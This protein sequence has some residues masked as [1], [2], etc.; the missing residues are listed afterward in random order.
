MIESAFNLKQFDTSE[1]WCQLAL[2]EAFKNCGQVNRGK[3]ERYVQQ[4][5]LLCP[6]DPPDSINRRLLLCTIF[7]GDSVK[8]KSTFNSM[9]EDTQN[10]ARTLYLMY[11]LAISSKDKSLA[12]QCLQNIS[13]IPSP[14]DY[15]Y[16]CV[17]ES[18][19]AGDILSAVDAL[20]AVLTNEASSLSSQTH[21]PALLRCIIRLLK[22]WLDSQPEEEPQRKI[23]IQDLCDVFD[24]GMWNR[25]HYLL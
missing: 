13:K 16:A 24:D 11:R 5:S 6:A 7:K 2:H 1:R 14:R 3:L 12:V 19:R 17:I 9:T 20:R 23:R 22:S 25:E 4:T 10:D 15:L 8:A 21:T 18:Q